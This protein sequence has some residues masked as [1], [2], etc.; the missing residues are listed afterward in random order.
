MGPEI[1][2][3]K[4]CED[5]AAAYTKKTSAM[6]L[7]FKVPIADVI[8][9]GDAFAAGFVSSILPGLS[10]EE[11]LENVTLRSLSRNS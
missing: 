8:G 3:V 1:V 5:G 6:K 7:A 9:A 4:L 10:L 11:A 2:V